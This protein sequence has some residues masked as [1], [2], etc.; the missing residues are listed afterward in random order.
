MSLAPSKGKCVRASYDRFWLCLLLVETVAHVL[1]INQPH[2]VVNRNQNNN[3]ITF[4]SQ[5][6]IAL[7]FCCNVINCNSQFHC[8]TRSLDSHFKLEHSNHVLNKFNIHG[9]ELFSA[10]GA[11]PIKLS[12]E[13]S[14]PF[15]SANGVQSNHGL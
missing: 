10:K 12:D 1:S 8:R 14:F 9:K 3:E 6:E 5:L 2:S 4:D 7:Y 15:S 13:I 11:S